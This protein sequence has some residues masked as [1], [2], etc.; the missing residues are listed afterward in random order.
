MTEIMITGKEPGWMNLGTHFDKTAT[1]QDVLNSGLGGWNVR[2]VPMYYSEGL[3]RTEF[4]KY[5]AVVGDINGKT[6]LLGRGII[7]ANQSILQNEEMIDFC[8][9]IMDVS[10]ADLRFTTAGYLGGTVFITV[11]MAEMFALSNGEELKPY[12]LLAQRHDG[13]MALQAKDVITRPICGNTLEMALGERNMI[14]FAIRHTINM[15]D[16][17]GL[18]VQILQWAIN[19]TYR[20]VMWANL[21]EST[22]MSDREVQDFVIALVPEPDSGR[23]KMAVDRQKAILGW[24]HDHPSQEG[25]R[26]TRWGAYNA[27][28]GAVD[29]NWPTRL[30]ETRLQT[31]LLLGTGTSS[32]IKQ[33]AFDRLIQDLAT[34]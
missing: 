29:H 8:A 20:K 31:N 18:A 33:E 30:P 7:G 25:I 12:F 2:K 24:Y 32:G 34:V 28:T 10:Q 6:E 23:V 16:R 4:D 27:V 14:W 19:Q 3:N 15:A 26:G 21:L 5:M 13:T 9:R 17:L 22:A 1:A 11:D